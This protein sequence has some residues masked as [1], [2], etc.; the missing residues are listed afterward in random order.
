ML[1][2]EV[3]NKKRQMSVFNNA[4]QPGSD[5]KELDDL[6]KEDGN[7]EHYFLTCQVK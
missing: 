4:Y 1:D 2:K 7:M 6:D 3:R 5:D